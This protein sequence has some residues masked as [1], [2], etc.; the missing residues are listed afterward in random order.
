MK[1]NIPT[2]STFGLLISFYARQAVPQSLQKY[3]L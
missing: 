3:Q 1:E 2:I